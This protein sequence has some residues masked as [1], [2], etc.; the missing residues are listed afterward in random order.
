MKNPWK[1]RDEDEFFAHLEEFVEVG[2]GFARLYLI[3][4]ND[5]ELAVSLLARDK[6]AMELAAAVGKALENL[7]VKQSTD[8][9]CACLTCGHLFSEKKDHPSAFIVWLPGADEDKHF[10]GNIAVACPVCW[11]CSKVNDIVM[12]DKAQE[13]IARLFSTFKVET[14]IIK[15]P[16][17]F[18]RHQS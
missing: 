15:E 18:R 12:L 14:T 5:V 16:K 6:L 4:Y 3:R 11:R 7:D 1:I 8:K 10:I 9:P 13:Q 17:P 2:Q